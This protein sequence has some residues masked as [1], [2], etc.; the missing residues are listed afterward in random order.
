[1]THKVFFI[2]TALIIFLSTLCFSDDQTQPEGIWKKVDSG[3]FIGI[4]DAP[5]K[6]NIGDSKITVVKIDPHYYKFKLLSA[7]EDGKQRMTAKEWCR[8][9]K[10]IG[11]INA[12]MYQEDLLTHVGYMKNFEYLNNPYVTK[13]NAILAFNRADTTVPEIQIIDRECQ[14]FNELR[15]KYNTLIQNIRMVNCRQQ[16]VWRQQAGKWS[17]AALGIDMEGNVLFI[18]SQSPYTAHDF[19]NI[20]LSL[21]ISLY[22]AMYLEGGAAASLYLSTVYLELNLSGNIE[23]GLNENNNISVTWPIPNVIGFVKKTQK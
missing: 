10:L 13:D 8:K 23:T 5:Q 11:A 17:I 1:M 15:E 6:S 7:K 2:L 14:D 20:L 19:I 21:P 22:N 18:F 3:L 9:Y 16:N 12:G 4:F